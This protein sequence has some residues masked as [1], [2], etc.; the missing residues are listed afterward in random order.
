M[1][2]PSCQFLHVSS[3]V[4]S[5]SFQFSCQ[6]I[7]VMHFMS[8]PFPSF[9]HT[10]NSYKPCPFFE[11]S[12]PARAGHYLVI[13]SAVYGSYCWSLSCPKFCQLI[14]C[15]NV[16]L[17]LMLMKPLRSVSLMFLNLK[18]EF[19]GL[20]SR[21]E[22]HHGKSTGNHGLPCHFLKVSWIFFTRNSMALLFEPTLLTPFCC[23]VG[24]PG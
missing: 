22:G 17:M 3:L 10:K 18:L 20:V 14:P 23:V 19:G 12:A 24:K 1:S 8:F 2:T 15:Q 4:S 9:Q 5:H 7:H 21:Y 13:S 6:F 11:T 16:F